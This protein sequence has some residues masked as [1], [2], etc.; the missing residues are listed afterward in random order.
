MP[1]QDAVPDVLPWNDGATRLRDRVAFLRARGVMLPD[2]TDDA[3]LA[4]TE[5]WLMPVVEGKRR[6]GDI[7]G[8]AL[9]EA[10]LGLLDWQQR[11]LIDQRAPAR[12]VTPAGSS[13]E[14]DYSA[15]AGPAV[16]VRVQALFGLDT[17][18]QA[19]GEPILLHLLSPAQRPLQTTR[20]LPGFWRGSWA[21][22]KAEMKGR[23]PRHNWPD[24]PWAAPPTLRTKRA[25]ER[26][27]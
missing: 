25:A 4:S 6:L 27:G 11:T 3:L 19:G 12:F 10:L 24:A 8:A 9:T 23:Y 17:H 15:E 16:S 26:A 5:A 14:I 22:V 7:D 2:M 18:P 13:H 20:D 1:D 21:A